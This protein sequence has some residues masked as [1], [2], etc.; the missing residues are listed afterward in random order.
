MIQY[1]IIVNVARFR[2]S[3]HIDQSLYNRIIKI[4]VI[5]FVK[6]YNTE[7]DEQLNDTPYKVKIINCCDLVYFFNGIKL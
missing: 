5:L 2:L 6:T 1:V 4:V 3:T 7:N